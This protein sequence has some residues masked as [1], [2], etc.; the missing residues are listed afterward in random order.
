M[1]V[2][3]RD[4]VAADVIRILTVFTGKTA[5]Q[6]KEGH[7]LLKDLQLRPDRLNAL[8]VSLRGYIKLHNPEATLVA[9]EIKKK[10]FTVGTTIDLVHKRIKGE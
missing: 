1:A 7:D 5:S 3:P 2:P 10:D 6:I 8:A 9:K 4:Q